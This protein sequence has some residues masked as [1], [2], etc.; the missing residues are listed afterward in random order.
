MR[1]K[2]RIA[3]LRA[4][5]SV[6]PVLHYAGRFSRVEEAS[7]PDA[8]GWSVVRMRFQ[9]E[10]DACGLALG[11]GTKVELL[12]PE[13]LRAKVSETAER[14]AEFYKGRAARA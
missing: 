10:E 14:V 13:S 3:T 11:F 9:F 4:H 7:G 8:E 2:A 5:K 12:E 6:V 1:S